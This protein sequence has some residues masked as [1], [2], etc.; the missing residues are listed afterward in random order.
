MWFVQ[1]YSCPGVIYVGPLTLRETHRMIADSFAL[2]SSAVAPK[3]CTPVLEVTRQLWCRVVQGLGWPMGWVG[4]DWVHYSKSINKIWDDYVAAQ[5]DKIWLHQAVKFH[6]TADLTKYRKSTRRSNKVIMLANVSSIVSCVGLGQVG[7]KIFHL[8]WVGLGWVS[9]L[10]S[11]VGSG[12]TTWTHGQL[13]CNAV[14]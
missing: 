2:V 12:H 11:C 1:L 9:Q 5:L 8:Q 10:M 3:S 6:F 4:L 14:T 13:Y 7:S